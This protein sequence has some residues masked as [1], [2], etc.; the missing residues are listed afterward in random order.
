METKKSV[1]RAAFPYTVPVMAGY[2]VL[3]IAYGILMQ[4]KGYSPIWALLI[5]L[6]AYSGSMQYAAVSLFTMPY[7][8]VNAFI[9]S[10]SVNA[11][12]LFCSVG[13][14]KKFRDFGK[15][16]PFLFFAL[17]DESFA[18]AATTEPPEGMDGG[19]FYSVIFL[20]NYL[21]W[22][23]GTLLG[24]LIGKMLPFSTAG[25]DFTLTAMYTAM[26]IDLLSDRK[27]RFC[28]VAGVICTLLARLVFGSGNLV[29]PALIFIL[30]VLIPARRS[31]L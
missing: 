1:F 8:P 28:G 25:L 31:K 19:K 24:G 30:C 13:M 26:F 2:L 9:L 29:I 20:L 6:L 7:N 10:V 14:L 16:R 11:R 27:S 21:Y 12:Y 22:A 23:S 15:Y 3:S 18:T 17:S 4:S 5:S